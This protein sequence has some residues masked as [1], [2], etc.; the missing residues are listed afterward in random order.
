MRTDTTPYRYPSLASIRVHLSV[1]DKNT[2]LC[3]LSKVVHSRGKKKERKTGEKE[4]GG[5][6][7]KMTTDGRALLL[8]SS[9]KTFLKL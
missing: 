1:F 9:V 2:I 4:P 6:E 8:L 5:Q 3:F 7:T